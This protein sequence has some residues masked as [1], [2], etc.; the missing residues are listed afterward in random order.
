[1]SVSYEMGGD[2]SILGSSDLATNSSMSVSPRSWKTVQMNFTLDL[3][4]YR[5]RDDIYWRCYNGESLDLHFVG[6]MSFS[7]LRGSVEELQFGP[8]LASPYCDVDI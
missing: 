7:K 5:A 1:M 6:F 2:Y 3:I 8:V 4:S